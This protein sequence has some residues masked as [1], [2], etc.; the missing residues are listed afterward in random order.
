MKKAKLIF[1]LL[2]LTFFVTGMT[3]CP[4]Y[5]SAK[6]IYR[7]SGYNPIKPVTY[8]EYVPLAYKKVN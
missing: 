2:A 6:P 5:A 8:R 1:A 3:S 7:T 4:T